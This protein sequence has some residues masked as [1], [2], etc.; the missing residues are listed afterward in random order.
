MYSINVAFPATSLWGLRWSEGQRS[1]RVFGSLDGPSRSMCTSEG[2]RLKIP[3]QVS[4]CAASP[5]RS[6]RNKKKEPEHSNS[7]D[8]DDGNDDDDDVRKRG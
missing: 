2:E 7:H 6:R 4:R 1:G 5:Q 3:P 8:G